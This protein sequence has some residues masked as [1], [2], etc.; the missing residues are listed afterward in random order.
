MRR[1]VLRMSYLLPS[2]GHFRAFP[3]RIVLLGFVLLIWCFNSWAC[4]NRTVWH[5]Y[6]T[7]K[8]TNKGVV[9]FL[10]TRHSEEIEYMK[11]IG[12]NYN[13]DRFFVDSVDKTKYLLNLRQH[14]AN[15]N[16]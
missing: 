14:R 9:T 3:V 16:F 8:A 15:E 6:F 13:D 12:Y 2:H 10:A 5:N 7:E 11:N 4:Y 1:F